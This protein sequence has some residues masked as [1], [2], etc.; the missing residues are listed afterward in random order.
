[1]RLLRFLSRVA[2]ICNICFLLAILVRYTPSPPEG[3]L[4]STIIV[5][6]FLV[7]IILNILVN[8]WLLIA[9]IAKGAMN[10]IP[11]WLRIGNG[12]FFVIQLYILFFHHDQQYT[13]GQAH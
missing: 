10:I 4:I 3:H 13:Q 2:F 7:G 8:I 9:W 11:L 1:M 12:L 5:L 6:G